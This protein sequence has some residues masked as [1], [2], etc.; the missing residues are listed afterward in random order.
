MGLIDRLLGRKRAAAA[1]VQDA[2][3]RARGQESYQTAEAQQAT[4]QRM[5]A[6]M[7][8]QRDRRAKA[9]PPQP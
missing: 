6:E 1:P 4:R 2:H 5:E 8:A 3:E 7:D 9:A